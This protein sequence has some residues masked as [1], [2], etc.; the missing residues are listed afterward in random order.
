MFQARL[1]FL[2]VEDAT[3]QVALNTTHPGIFEKIRLNRKSLSGPLLDEANNRAE[4]EMKQ[5]LKGKLVVISQD[6]WSNVHNQPII[7]TNLIYDGESFPLDYVYTG[8]EKKTA[9][10]CFKL[11][12]ESI[13]NA[14]KEYK[15]KVVGFVSDNESN[16]TILICWKQCYLQNLFKFR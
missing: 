5:C 11:L 16:P 2:A 4:N 13:N 7:A 14:E 10:Y 9:E 3:F 15:A 12:Q 8:S 6:G 1:P